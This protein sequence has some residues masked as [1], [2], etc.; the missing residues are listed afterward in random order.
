MSPQVSIITA[1]YNYGIYLPRAV[2]SVIDQTFQDWE[3][4]IID[5]GS[6]DQTRDVIKPYLDDK[7][8]RYIHTVNRGQPAAKNRGLIETKGRL[9]AFLDGDDSWFPEKLERQVKLITADPSLGVVYSRRAII[10]ESGT[11][12][13]N[14]TAALHRGNILGLIF[15]DNF[16]CFS[17]AMVRREAFTTVG[18]FDESIP[19]A[20]DYDLWLRIAAKYSFDYIDDPMVYYRTGHANL[21]RRSLE[22]LRIALQIMNRFV[23]GQGGRKLLPGKL[24]RK[25]Y[26]ETYAHLGELC[27]RTSKIASAKWYSQALVTSP[28][29]KEVWRVILRS[30]MPKLAKTI[31]RS[32]VAIASPNVDKE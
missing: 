4:I 15:K 24:K 10:S 5:D 21:S 28:F 19:M 6:E 11:F 16:I 32:V 14:D 29:S 17:S 8:I 1:T 27:M 9:I 30:T 7:R 22:R 13:G 25:A 31:L 23:N 26:A 18:G 3:L 12:V 20:I 2:E